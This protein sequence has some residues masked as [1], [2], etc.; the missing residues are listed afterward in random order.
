[1]LFCMVAEGEAAVE[2]EAVAAAEPA[3]AVAVAPG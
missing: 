2:E 1:M 3:V